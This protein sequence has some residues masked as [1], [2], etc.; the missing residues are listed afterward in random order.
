M[1]YETVVRWIAVS[2]GLPIP[3]A[4][5]RV[6]TARGVYYTDLAWRLRKWIG[7]RVVREWAIHAEF[8]GAMKYGAGTS[9]G[10][11]ADAARTVVNEK[12]REDAIRELGDTFRRF[13]R[14]DVEDEDNVFRRLC[15]AFP[16][17]MTVG[18]RPVPGLLAPPGSK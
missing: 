18:L 13:D 8:D 1:T 14:R 16:A 4:Q 12:L 15:A 2:R 6:V 5:Y 9:I 10:R 11:G 3:I 17:S 7:G